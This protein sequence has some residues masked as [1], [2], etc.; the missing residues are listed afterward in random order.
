MLGVGKKMARA[1]RFV[2]AVAVLVGSAFTVAPQVASAATG[3]LGGYVI[4]VNSNYPD[5][6][7]NGYTDGGF[8]TNTTADNGWFRLEAQAFNDGV[9]GDPGGYSTFWYKFKPIGGSY[10]NWAPVSG[11]G[12]VTR[13]GD[14]GSYSYYY[15]DWHH[16]VAGEYTF[17]AAY[18]DAQN[19]GNISYYLN[20]ETTNTAT[21]Y[22]LQSTWEAT[23]VNSAQYYLDNNGTAHSYYGQDLT[24]RGFI[25]SDKTYATGT[26]SLLVNQSVVDNSCSKVTL[27]PYPG[28][29]TEFPGWS[30]ISGK[31]VSTVSCTIPY[32]NFPVIDGHYEISVT[33]DGDA[34][35]LAGHNMFNN[36]QG[37]WAQ[38]D[39]TIGP[40][41]QITDQYPV[42]AT[43]NDQTHQ[44]GWID[45]SNYGYTLSNDYSGFKTAADGS[46]KLGPLFTDTTA[47]PNFSSLVTGD[48]NYSAPS[49][50]SSYN[51]YSYWDPT[52]YDIG[53]TG[54]GSQNFTVAS[55]F[56]G[57]LTI[58]KSQTLVPVSGAPYAVSPTTW[59]NYD[60]AEC[61]FQ[62]SKF[63]IDQQFFNN[64]RAANNQPY[65]QPFGLG[66][67][68]TTLS[69]NPLGWPATGG[70]DV[71]YYAWVVGTS[72]SPT[73]TVAFYADGKL[74]YGCGAQQL[75]GQAYYGFG[76][77]WYHDN[78]QLLS[79]ALSIASCTV[80]DPAVNTS[81][82]MITARYSG[83]ADYLSASTASP[84]KQVI[85]D[86]ASVTVSSNQ[87]PT[88]SDASQQG[89]MV[90]LT[91][92]VTGNA[93]DPNS[94]NGSF[95][96]A[97]T[98]VV[99]F[100]L[101]HVEI[102]GCVDL[103]LYNNNGGPGG[104]GSSYQYCD[105]PAAALAYGDTA[106]AITVA[107][108]GDWQYVTAQTA[109]PYFQVI[110]DQFPLIAQS[111]IVIT[112][113]ASFSLSDYL[114]VSYTGG[115]GNG[116]VNIAITGGTASG[117]NYDY[118]TNRVTATSVGTCILTIS[119]DG[120]STYLPAS[121]S[122]TIR[123][124][125]G[126]QATLLV[127][128]LSGPYGSPIT[129]VATGGSGNGNITFTVAKGTASGCTISNGVLSS[130]SAGTCLVTARKA[131]DANYNST[132][133][134]AQVITF[135]PLP[136]AAVSLAS[137]TVSQ[138]ALNL[139]LAG[140]GGS[141]TGAFSFGLLPG[142]TATGCAVSNN[143]LSWSSVGT[144]LVSVS[145]AGDSIYASATGGP[146][147]VTIS[148]GAVAPAAQARLTLTAAK[149]KAAKGT[150]VALSV[151]GG[152]GTGAVTLVKVSGSCTLNGS[153]VTSKIAG[154][155][156]VKALKAGS[157]GFR[158][159]SSSVVRVTFR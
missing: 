150:S 38:E 146:F 55:H 83:D 77:G 3:A 20:Q 96:I 2:P 126:T 41:W 51:Y 99:T 19:N 92:T 23:D 102:P 109:A 136:Q 22:V 67:N 91:A 119:K 33:Y 98:G 113:S 59:N 110:V 134:A 58:K 115:S 28:A 73:G 61:N 86:P 45:P 10:G 117:C 112:N 114:L 56:N 29:Q 159:V 16:P 8:N 43:G 65:D 131:G 130:L 94:P 71:T 34:G 143:V 21:E 85:S 39:V 104:S 129:L 72:S 68:A 42:V 13:N 153:K 60:W 74:I 4:Y 138:S 7:P 17:K 54:G 30:A 152:S 154:A 123:V 62:N 145:R 116:A 101:N 148:A 48:T 35:H 46:T 90:H 124:L 105:I 137:T 157:N 66:D 49:C 15:C 93:L 149:L 6:T 141:G 151:R 140:S 69:Q 80:T 89:N 84:M 81:G 76:Y 132:T 97:P 156:T 122:L 36:T 70:Q 5:L 142:G 25:V 63:C 11:C 127:T 87:N 50:G 100:Y 158:A 24:V 147:T 27:T 139:A 9:V 128:P 108:S 103:N 26:A 155:C 44:Y 133:S 135:N 64:H 118:E 1:L 121:T 95:P 57:T 82:V 47:F 14:T 120:D 106:N 125:K 79:S 32:T 37:N 31:K 75:Y 53:C 12:A 88:L 40:W 18:A 52:T 144:C 78:P 107:Y 111:P